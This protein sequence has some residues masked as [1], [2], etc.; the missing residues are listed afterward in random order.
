MTEKPAIEEILKKI[1]QHVS[2]EEKTLIKAYL[3]NSEALTPAYRDK[4]AEIV[5]QVMLNYPEVCDKINTGKKHLNWIERGLIW[6]GITASLT[7]A[8][9]VIFKNQ[10][11]E[12]QINQKK[13][14]LHDITLERDAF[15]KEFN[16]INARIDRFEKA[17]SK[18]GGKANG[19]LEDELAVIDGI[20]TSTDNGKINFDKLKEKYEGTI[21]DLES[22]LEMQ[23]KLAEE[24]RDISEKIKEK[25]A[26]LEEKWK[27][28]GTVNGDLEDELNNINAAQVTANSECEKF[29]KEAE[30]LKKNSTKLEEIL[31]VSLTAYRRSDNGVHYVFFNLH[32]QDGDNVTNIMEDKKYYISKDVAEKLD[33][34]RILSAGKFDK[35]CDR[36]WIKAEYKDGA[37][38]HFLFSEDDKQETVQSM[39]IN[40]Q[41]IIAFIQSVSSR[42]TK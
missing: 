22:K 13:I 24:Y 29:K 7:A 28:Y 14:Q 2:P 6:L 33:A 5:K 1:I 38:Q 36:L 25:T 30:D 8:Y 42:Y 23:K 40:K 37:A 17:A 21:T 27:E 10:D 16:D 19:S 20:M 15:K 4:A 11:M 12:N 35:P 32:F 31:F 41:D 3:T 18:Y 9:F 39:Q 26:K 34:A